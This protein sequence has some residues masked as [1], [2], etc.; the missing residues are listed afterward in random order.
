M[1]GRCDYLGND[2]FWIPVSTD[3]CAFRKNI[4]LGPKQQQSPE[5][6]PTGP[7]MVMPLQINIWHLGKGR[8]CWEGLQN[9]SVILLDLLCNQSTFHHNS[10]A[11]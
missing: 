2:S 1:G 3:I 6:T 8:F 5:I 7:I 9:T 10:T 11:I 4:W